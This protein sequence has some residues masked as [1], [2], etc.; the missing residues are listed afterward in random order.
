MSVQTEMT[1]IKNAVTAI[2]NAITSKG[3]T[4]P[5]GTKID[6]LAPLISSISSGGASVATCTVNISSSISINNSDFVVGA[7]TF[8]DGK[9]YTF[10]RSGNNYNISIP[11]VVC[12]STLFLS[13]GTMSSIYGWSGGYLSSWNS[14][15]HVLYVPNTAGT[16]SAEIGMLDD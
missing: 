2:I 9:I 1:R 3:V 15:S 7:T 14:E 11:N 13:V 4:V 5:S 16:Y 6:G 10:A 8:Q 12:G